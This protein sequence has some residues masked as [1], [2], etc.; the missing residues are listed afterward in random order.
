MT[1]KAHR[2]LQ[3]LEEISGQSYVTQ[4]GL[5][6]K[7][8]VALGL[9]NLLIYRLARKGYIKVVNLQRNRLHYLIT[10]QGLAEKSRLTCEY[11]EYSLQ[12]YRQIR[13]FLTASLTP[14]AGAGCRNILL[15]GTGEVAEIAYLTMQEMDLNLV[16]V[17]DGD[18]DRGKF[19]GFPVIS[20]ADLPLTPFDRI[21]IAGFTS[22]E[23]IQQQLQ[24]LGIPANKMIAIPDQ[25][26]PGRTVADTMGRAL[27]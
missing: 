25:V 8:G 13:R 4:R 1:F 11:L 7:L 22:R 15:Y 14:L 17:L 5:A 26:W 19:L 2:E 3:L 12:F 23:K 20:L 21:V 16:G 24:A 6:K 9:T 10:P 27:L 18:T